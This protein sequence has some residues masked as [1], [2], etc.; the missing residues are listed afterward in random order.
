MANWNKTGKVYKK[1]KQLI[2]KEVLENTEDCRLIKDIHG[3]GCVRPDRGIMWHDG[4][5]HVLACKIAKPF[6]DGE[7][8]KECLHG[9]RAISKSV[10]LKKNCC[11]AG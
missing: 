2:L 6:F 8:I 1:L 10:P 7:F 9:S 5:S 11:K 4:S 3:R